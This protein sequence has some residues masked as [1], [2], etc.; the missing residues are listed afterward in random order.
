MIT[1]DDVLQSRLVADPLRLYDC[2]PI[3]DGSA[4]LVLADMDLARKLTDTP[5]EIAG[6]TVATGSGGLHKRVSV[7]SFEAT[8]LSAAKA[9]GME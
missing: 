6:S 4:A 8:K 1:V 2:C 9:F 7:T 3:G 5:I